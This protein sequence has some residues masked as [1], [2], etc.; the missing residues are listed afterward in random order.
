MKRRP[1]PQNTR[2]VRHI[3]KNERITTTNKAN[4]TVQCESF[5][6]FKLILLLERDPSVEDYIS[7]PEEIH[8]VDTLSR[9]KSYT[10]DFK[11]L[12]SDGSVEIHEV[13][14]ESRRK[15]KPQ[16]ITREQIAA[17]L[18]A[19]RQ[20]KYVVHTDE[21]LPSGGL[22]ANL[23]LL[24]GYRQAAYCDTYIANFL[25]AMVQN[26]GPIWLEALIN[27]AAETLIKPISEIYGT[28]L[29]LI[30]HS[31]LLVK[32]DQLLFIDTFPVNTAYVW[33]GKELKND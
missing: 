21:T 9:R 26:T 5:N 25:L 33:F 32:M 6:E 11:V 2:R 12:R 22:L 24:Y 10:P 30:W 14:V 20:W 27:Q 28:C 23:Q 3:D 13:T 7:Q 17:E 29:H 19:M 15:E 31:N 18:C 8:Y 1:P 16:L 4:R